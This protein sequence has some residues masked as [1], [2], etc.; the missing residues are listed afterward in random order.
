[1]EGGAGRG[2]EVDGGDGSNELRRGLGCWESGGGRCTGKLN[3][4]FS[5]SADLVPNPCNENLLRDG[6]MRARR[7]PARSPPV[8]L[9]RLPLCFV[10]PPNPHPP[11]V[12]PRSPKEK[13]PAIRVEFRGERFI[14]FESH[15]L[16]RYFLSIT[17]HPGEMQKTEGGKL[18]DN[19]PSTPDYEHHA[20]IIFV[21]L[22]SSS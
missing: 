10:P 1:M 4:M 21:D 5:A 16:D 8:F 6:Q 7:D 13:R 20:A 22:S 11:A 15:I 12:T 9:S 18:R 17:G 14:Y 3:Y 19:S 2:C